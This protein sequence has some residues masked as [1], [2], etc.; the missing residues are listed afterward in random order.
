MK[1]IVFFGG[2]NIAQ[3]IIKGLIDSGY[4]K[5]NIFYVDRNDNNQKELKKLGIKKLSSKNKKID[6]FILAVKPKDAIDAFQ[7]I[8]KENTKPKIVSLV[9]GVKAKRYKALKEKVEIMRAMPNTSSRYGYGITALFNS[10]FN[11]KDSSKVVKLFEKIGIVISVKKESKI[12]TFTGMIGSG[13]AYFFFL[14]KSYEKKLLPLCNGNKQKVNEIIVNL[15]KGIG[16]S[17]ENDKDLDKLISAV[18]SK[19]GTTE[20]GLKSFKTNKLNKI[21]EEGLKVAIK[22]SEEISNEY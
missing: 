5:A 7:S 18:A 13:P 21:F 10:S 1:N 6:L 19:K 15:I 22:R 4:S 3:S 17:I 2:G 8:L 11:Q 9:A 16:A 20:A 12:D 14:L